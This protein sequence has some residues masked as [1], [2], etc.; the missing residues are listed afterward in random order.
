MIRSKKPVFFKS[1]TRPKPDT[2]YDNVHTS[3]NFI[4]RHQRYNL[5]SFIDVANKWN[6]W[7]FIL[8]CMRLH[9]SHLDWFKFYLC[10][11]TFCA[12]REHGYEQTSLDN[13][14]W[15]NSTPTLGC[16]WQPGNIHTYLDKFVALLGSWFGTRF[17]IVDHH[18]EAL[19]WWVCSCMYMFKWIYM[20]VLCIK[21]K[22]Y[23]KD[24]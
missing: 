12:S 9:R 17:H 5:H 16:G 7:L 8:F 15:Y 13:N 20:H 19:E 11:S 18:S 22:I 21:M 10:C 6:V 3:P 23:N 14:Q 4:C 24:I 2:V 1:S